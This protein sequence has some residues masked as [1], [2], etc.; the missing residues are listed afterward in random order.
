MSD[1]VSSVLTDPDSIDAV[2]DVI[3][4]TVSDNLSD[5]ITDNF[6]PLPFGPIGII[7]LLLG[8]IF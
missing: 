2:T 1:T 5:I 8:I 4:D 3:G 6:I 7:K